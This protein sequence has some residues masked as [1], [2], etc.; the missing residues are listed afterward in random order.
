MTTRT[1]ANSL[2]IW[3]TRKSRSNTSSARHSFRPS[4]ETLSDRVV[5]AHGS[6]CGHVYQDA[7][8]NGLSADDS[9]LAGV[10]VKLYRD[11]N[12]DGVL[13]CGDRLVAARKSGESGCYRFDHLRAGRYFVTESVPRGFVRTA[14]VLDSYYTVNLGVGQRATGRHFDNYRKPCGQVVSSFN[15]TV[16][17]P[18]GT[19]TTVNNLRGH[20]EAG[21]TI[22]ANFT[23][24]PN[25]RPVVVTLVS[26][27]AP[28]ASF[29]P[30]T[31]S[32][33]TVFEIATG[34]FGPGE[35]SLTVHLPNS[36]YQVDF[37][38]G[39][40]IDHFGPAGS[41]IFY[42]PQCRLLSAD[43]GGEPPTWETGSISGR[44]FVDRNQDGV[45][46]ASAGDA[47]LALV[48]VNL[49]SVDANGD[50]TFVKSASTA[51]DGTYSF[52]NLAGGNYVLVETQPNDHDDGL[53]FA[54][55]AGGWAGDPGAW[56]DEISNI[57]LATGQQGENYVF[58]E[59]A[60]AASLSGVAGIPNES[61]PTGF[62][63]VSGQTL[64]V[65]LQYVDAN[66][67][68]ITLTTEANADDGSFFFGS[69]GI[70]TYTLSIVLPDGFSAT[71]PPTV[72]K[73]NGVVDGI[74]GED[75]TSIAS[76]VLA[77]HDAG[78]GY[79]FPIFQTI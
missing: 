63:W 52:A 79:A 24:A 25:S 16:I 53:D 18:D 11:S 28:G 8:G 76:I 42:T 62:V 33:Q 1:I 44:V 43:N 13:N 69:L 49:Y 34:T 71:M 70:G 9:A 29:D 65:V 7:T 31:A 41:N 60:G 58:T 40:A 37:V 35:H 20:T 68:T 5:P 12:H 61:S 27:N 45:L 17:S 59:L 73:V 78:V 75:N 74:A 39:Y 10:T 66:G 57:V 77:D 22:V 30:R 51:A 54:G 67:I 55:S 19:Q 14:P 50:R 46:D 48:Q 15:F 72:G 4:L 38:V 36:F 21:D 26:Y 23:V 64:T 6:I 3:S 56:N 2:R 47:P 32:Q